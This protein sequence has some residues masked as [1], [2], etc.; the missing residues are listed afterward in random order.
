MSTAMIWQTR[1]ISSDETE[2]LG[3]VLGRLLK[4]GEVIE[5]QSDLGSGKTTFVRGLARGMGSRDTVASPTFTLS[6]IYRAKSAEIHHFD[7]YRLNDPGILSD[8]LR[9]SLSNPKVVTV[10]E[11]G[12]S[13]QNVLPG[14]RMTI[15]LQPLGSDS[16]ERKVIVEYPESKTGLIK[17]LETSWKA[18]RP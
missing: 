8:Q 14:R 17:K 12:R 11:W 16:R 13:V 7:F 18:L 1:C 2:W 4:A 5:L 10:V 15:K 3:E 6:N 9:E